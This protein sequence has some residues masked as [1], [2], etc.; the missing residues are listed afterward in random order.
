MSN[1]SGSEASIENLRAGRDALLA[2]CSKSMPQ[3]FSQRMALLVDCY[4]NARLAEAVVKGILPD[5]TG[6]SVLAVG[7][8]GRGKLSPFSDLDVLVLTDLSKADVLEN[9]A[10]FLFHPLW[11]LKFEVGHGVRS[12]PQNIELA[13]SDFKVLASLLD[14]RFIAGNEELFKTLSGEFTQKVLP[15]AGDSFC[16]TLWEN[17][18]AVGVGMDSVVLE[19]DLK[20]G[21]GTLRDVQFVHWCAG[22]K[23]DYLPLNSDDLA[24]LRRDETLLIRVRS[25]LHLTAGRKQDRLDIERLADVA[26]LCGVKGYSPGKRGNDLLNELHA[27]MIRIRSMGD[28]LYRESFIKDSQQFIKWSGPISLKSALNL[29]KIKSRNGN[30]LTREARRAVANLNSEIDICLGDVLNLLIK[31]LEAPY[32]WRSS[33]EMLDSGVFNSFLPEFS[34]VAALIPYDGYHR[35]PPGRHSLLTVHKCCDIN[36]DEFEGETLTPADLDILMLGAFFH[37]IGKGGRDH[38]KRGAEITAE[39]LSRTTFP[40]EFKDDIIF[41]VREHLL[42]VKGARRIDLSDGDSLLEIAR[43]V[44]TTRRLKLLFILSMADSMATGPRVWNS[45]SESLLRELYSGLE[46]ILAEASVH[47][48]D[49][50]QKIGETRARVKILSSEIMEGSLVDLM[51]DAMPDRYLLS[52]EPEEIVCHIEQVIEFNAAYEK[53]LIRKPC[54]KG[55][56]GLNLVRSVENIA[57]GRTRI[58]ITARDQD[59]LF[60]AQAGVLALHSINIL[61]ADIFSWS[62]GTAV[63]IF[64][65]ESP[66]AESAPTDLWARVERAI[67]Y[68]MTGRLSLDYRLHKKRNSFFAKTNSQ[69]VPTQIS[70]DND[71][72]ELCTIIEVRTQDRSGILYDM[73]VTFS[74]M[75]VDLR[76][77]RISTTGSSVF[78]VFHVENSG[79]G[80]IEDSEYVKELVVALEYAVSSAQ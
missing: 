14:L 20:N 18:K 50:D 31:I 73:A 13:K 79:W 59:F 39:I 41:L 64:T 61:S 58:V 80:K 70:V 11:D 29:F 23:G 52:L 48:F 38:H 3:D 22:V 8:Y 12:V 65:V 21:W 75:N 42:L 10:A 37:D 34:K 36:K 33:L 30:P 49:N 15:V 7:G 9:L 68:A 4:F 16:R 45:W 25:A 67:M 28:A 77:A 62:D 35:Y 32:G 44:G 72:S 27:A 47:E 19:P 60:A 40:S 6:L 55:G 2:A 56:K 54:G 5:C 24:D 74:R 57:D 43:K 17:R 63:N 26:S 78:D 66:S 46:Q 71:S 76:M 69:K 53:D 1:L 51:L